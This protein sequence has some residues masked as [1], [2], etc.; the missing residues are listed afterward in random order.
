MANRPCVANPTCVSMVTMQ[1]SK[2][3]QQDLHNSNGFTNNPCIACIKDNLTLWVRFDD[4]L[5]MNT[6]PIIGGKN[7]WQRTYCFLCADTR[8][9]T[10]PCQKFVP[11]TWGFVFVFF[12]LFSIIAILS[13]SYSIK[14]V[15]ITLPCTSSSF[16]TANFPMKSN[17]GN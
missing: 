6:L 4:S 7:Q 1:L 15:S 10:S 11:G 14:A 5:G 3:A 12:P 9:Q 17:H 13:I 2:A 16:Q 8:K